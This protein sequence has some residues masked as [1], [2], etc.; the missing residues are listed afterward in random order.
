MYLNEKHFPFIS[1]LNKI[2]NRNAIK[3]SYCG[4]DKVA[5]HQISTVTLEV[6]IAIIWR[7]N[8]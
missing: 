6:E 3:F 4:M 1:K 8:I 5:Q 2:F 7:S